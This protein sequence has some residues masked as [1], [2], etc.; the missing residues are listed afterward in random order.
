MALAWQR[1]LDFMNWILLITKYEV[2]QAL[3]LAKYSLKHLLVISRTSEH[4]LIDLSPLITC[5]SFTVLFLFDSHILNCTNVRNSSG[6]LSRSRNQ[7]I[8][9]QC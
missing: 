9:L 4:F 3:V 2:E 8:E 1:L 5:S 6:S 7:F